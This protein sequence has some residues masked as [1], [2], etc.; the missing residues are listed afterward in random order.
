MGDE[1]LLFVISMPRSGSTLVQAVLSNTISVDTISEPWFLLPFLSY[2]R[3][4]INAATYNSKLASKGIENFKTRIGEEE[5]QK[6]LREFLL[7]QYAKI[8]EENSMYFLDK[9]PRYYEILDEIVEMFPNSKIIV[10]RRNPIAVLKSM[11]KKRKIQ[12]LEELH[13]NYRDLIKAPFLLESFL[14]KQKDNPR[15]REV[16]YEKMMKSPTSEFKGLFEWL[17]IEEFTDDL[18]D[19]SENTKFRGELGD[20]KGIRSGKLSCSNGENWTDIYKSSK[21]GDFAQGYAGFLGKSYMDKF[22]GSELVQYNDSRLFDLF[23]AGKTEINRERSF[24]F[25][26][27]FRRF[28][29]FFSK[30]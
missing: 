17:N 14:D 3:L 6:G 21:W 20:Q 29:N 5:F 2:S 1:S 18:L 7:S 22:E 25:G 10:L 15:V 12:G 9:T 26:S 11:I 4:D 19:F 8:K 13:K 30:W 24:N 28:S 23:F 27:M 16:F